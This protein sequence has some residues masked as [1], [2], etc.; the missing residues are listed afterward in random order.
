MEDQP[1]IRDGHSGLTRS[2]MTVT[3]GDSDGS[4]KFS[5]GSRGIGKE[6]P[7]RRQ[8]PVRSTTGWPIPGP[9]RTD[10]ERSS[11][12]QVPR[13]SNPASEAVR[14]AGASEELQSRC[15]SATEP[16]EI[17]AAEGHA[18]AAEGH[19]A[20]GYWLVTWEFH[21]PMGRVKNTWQSRPHLKKKLIC[22][23]CGHR[24]QCNRGA[25]PFCF[26]PGAY[27]ST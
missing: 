13:Q 12:V 10:T 4:V 8:G 24:L 23:C 2:P 11:H 14:A 27:F 16:L 7:A 19:A 20:K 17:A 6:T 25:F 1:S 9:G 15:P 3:P 5:S 18:A 22:S 21:H 26:G